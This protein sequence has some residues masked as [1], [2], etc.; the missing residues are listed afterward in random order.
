MEISNFTFT[1]LSLLAQ[2]LMMDSDCWNRVP[3]IPMTSAISWLTAITTWE[4]VFQI[5]H[6]V[7]P[8]DCVFQQKKGRIDSRLQKGS[9]D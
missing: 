2:L 6:Q 7:F 8:T 9:L 3:P 1:V 4:N 5:N